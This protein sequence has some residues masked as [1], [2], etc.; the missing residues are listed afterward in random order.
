[1]LKQQVKISFTTAEE[2]D[3][4]GFQNLYDSCSEKA[5]DVRYTQKTP[6]R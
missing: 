5:S 2:V 4:T 6:Q 1:M 3:L